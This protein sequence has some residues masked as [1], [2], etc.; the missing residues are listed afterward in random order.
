MIIAGEAGWLT[1]CGQSTP[2]Q[3]RAGGLGELGKI[4]IVSGLWMIASL[5]SIMIERQRAS[6]IGKAPGF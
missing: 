4:I 1:I 3:Q 2:K 5:I 6:M